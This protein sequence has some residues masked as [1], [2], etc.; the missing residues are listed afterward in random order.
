M[1]RGLVA[2]HVVA[3]VVNQPMAW[4]LVEVVGALRLEA[5]VSLPRLS[6]RLRLAEF[7]APSR[8]VVPSSQ[9]LPEWASECCR[10]ANC[11][12]SA[13]ISN[14]VPARVACNWGV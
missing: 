12:F 6:E 13:S 14:T 2:T 10:A 5:F 11:F 9:L 8:P 1:G 3:K 4:Y 7:S